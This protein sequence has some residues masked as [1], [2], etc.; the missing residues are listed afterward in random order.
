M[1]HRT[2]NSDRKSKTTFC[3]KGLVSSYLL[4]PYNPER[5]DYYWRHGVDHP[6]RRM[7]QIKFSAI[8]ETSRPCI[9]FGVVC[10]TSLNIV[11]GIP[12]AYTALATCILC[13]FISNLTTK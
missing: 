4:F 2:V 5:T 9:L 3:L 6:Y 7:K 11:R 12:E 13:L 1:T 8:T 10:H